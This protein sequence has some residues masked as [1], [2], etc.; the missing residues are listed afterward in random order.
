MIWILG[1]KIML[2]ECFVSGYHSLPGIR[3][4]LEIVSWSDL[5]SMSPPT[6]IHALIVLLQKQNEG[7]PPKIH[8]GEK[9]TRV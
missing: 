2:Q 9:Q 7:K 8:K 6:R 3:K 1:E 5:I 4:I